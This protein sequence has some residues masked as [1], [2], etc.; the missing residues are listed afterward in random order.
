MENDKYA[1]IRNK[2]LFKY[3]FKLGEFCDL[4]ERSY[5]KSLSQKKNL[6]F[7]SLYK[8]ARQLWAA[9]Y[10]L[11]L[12]QNQSV[13]HVLYIDFNKEQSIFESEDKQK[14]REENKKRRHEENFNRFL[15]NFIQNKY[16]EQ[17]NKY[18]KDSSTRKPTMS[19]SFEAFEKKLKKMS[20]KFPDSQIPRM[21]KNA[22]KEKYKRE[23]EKRKQFCIDN[24][25]I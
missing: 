19:F 15:V 1:S 14:Y 4:Y 21:S 24:N 13:E 23:L 3:K 8:K 12:T 16:E 11:G 9:A 7:K 25:L 18:E 2:K 10:E 17:K 5:I 6:S 20:R 22:I